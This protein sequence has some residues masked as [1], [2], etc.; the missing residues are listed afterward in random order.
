M[1]PIPPRLPA[2]DPYDQSN[3]AAAHP[4]KVAAMQERLNALGREAAKPLA[5]IHTG[6]AKPAPARRRPASPRLV[7]KEENG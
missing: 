2:A 7:P 3:L 5:L 4:E 6:E 1:F